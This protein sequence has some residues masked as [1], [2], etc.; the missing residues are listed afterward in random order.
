MDSLG[1]VELRNS[2]AAR[3]SLELPATLMFDYPT[4]DSLAAYLTERLSTQP[5]QLAAELAQQQQQQQPRQV[6]HPHAQHQCCR[7]FGDSWLS[8]SGCCCYLLSLRGNQPGVSRSRL[9]SAADD[10]MPAMIACN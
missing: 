8:L 10:E 2:I 7:A 9:I 6:R 1:A 3:F 5:Q 4:T